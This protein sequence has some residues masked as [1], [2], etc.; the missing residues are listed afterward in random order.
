MSKENKNEESKKDVIPGFRCVEFA[1]KVRDE[2]TRKWKDD[3]EA[4]KRDLE[5]IRK[6]YGIKV[7]ETK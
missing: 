5:E 3:P 1:R 6:K 4:K 2:L 7:P